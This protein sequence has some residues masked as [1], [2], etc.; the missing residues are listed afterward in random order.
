MKQGLNSQASTR[1]HQTAHP[2]HTRSIPVSQKSTVEC[3]RLTRVS[4][5]VCVHTRHKPECPLSSIKAAIEKVSSLSLTRYNTSTRTGQPSS[6]TR[7]IVPTG[8]VGLRLGGPPSLQARVPSTCSGAVRTA[9]VHFENRRPSSDTRGSGIRW[10]VAS[11]PIEGT[12][13]QSKLKN[14]ASASMAGTN[15]R[16][17]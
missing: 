15:S 6:S 5:C 3:S 16:H 11:T 10:Q 14:D 12:K 4:A 17:Q 8:E 13:A 7:A 1:T 2:R 9:A